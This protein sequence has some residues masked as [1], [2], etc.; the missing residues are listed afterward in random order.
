MNDSETGPDRT[1]P[2]DPPRPWWFDAAVASLALL[3]ATLARSSLETVLGSNYPF[4]TYYGAVA[5]VAWFR[6]TAA[7]IMTLVI[8]GLLGVYLFTTDEPNAIVGLALYLAVAGVVVSMGHAMRQARCRA[9]SLLAEAVV[10]QNELRS[11]VVAEA[12]QRE[13]QIAATLESVKDGF[14]RFDRDWRIVYAN[15]EAERINRLERGEMLGRN[16]WELFP[17]LVGSTLETEFRRAVEQQ[18]TVE[19]ENRYE[20]WGRWYALKGYPTPDGGLTTFIRDITE[21][22]AQREAL[23]ES[24]ARYRAIGESIDFGVW[25]CDATGRNIYASKSFL[26]M[27]GLT[28]QQCSNMG[29]G[30]VLHPDD[31]EA[32]IAAW[33]EC[34][35]RRGKWDREHRIKGVDGQWY[36]VLARGVP[37]EN[38]AGESLGWAGINLDITRFV[39]T[40]REVARIAGE[41][42][43][44]RRLYETV[45]TNTPDFVYVFSLDHK[46]VYANDALLKMWGLGYEDAIGKTFLEIGYEPWHA[47][48]HDREIDLVRATRQPIR[49]EVPFNGTNGLRQYDYIFVPVIGADG[50]VEA[51]A[52]TTRDITDRLN[53]EER[54]RTNEERQTYRVT[55]ADSIRPLSDPAAVQAEAI[56]VLGE[57]IDASRVAYFEIHGDDFVVEQDYTDGVASMAGRYPLAAF[58]T[59]LMDAY[60]SGRNAIEAD[61]D[62]VDSLTPQERAAFATIQTRA[63]VG[64]PLVKDGSFVGGLAIHSARPR[65]WTSTE[66]SLVEETAERTWAAVERVRAESALRTSEER[67]RTLFGTMDEGFCVIDIEFDPAGRAIDYQIDVMNPAFEE[68]TG[69]QG[70][71]GKS[72]R[73]TVPALE[74][75]WF[76]TYGRVASTGETARFVH[77]AGPMGGRWFDVSAFRLGG[78]GSNKVGILFRDITARKHADAERE[79][80]VSQ[81][82]D[83]DRRKDEFLATLAHELRNPLAPIRN[84][85]QLIR[86][87]GAD[88]TIE[89]A[90]SMMERQLAQLVRLVDDLLDMNR[91]T[92]GKLELRRER[93]ELSA[94]VAAALETSRLL[95]EQ[96]G[97]ELS[98][99][100]PDESIFVD[101]DPVRLAQAVSNLLTNSAKYTHQGGRIRLSVARDDAM[102]TLT[103]ADDGIGIP[104]DMLETVFEMFTQVDRSLEKTTGGLGIGLSLVKGLV[105]MHGGTIVARSEGEGRGS[106]FVMRLPVAEFRTDVSAP[107]NADGN[108]AAPVGPRRILIV[109]DNID[110]ADSLGELLEVMGNEVRTVYDGAAAVET[111]RAFRPCV[112]LCDIGMPVLNGYDTA[113]R[114]RAEA[115]SKDTVLVAVTGWGQDGDLEKSAEAGFDH[116]LVKPVELATLMKLLGDHHPALG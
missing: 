64:V 25:V 109:D 69:M 67:L 107:G 83:Q 11:S 57:W 72:I 42:E 89:H 48:M 87:A 34:V 10:R 91:V 100:L 55:L 6:G 17:S 105:E 54:L 14:I 50:E 80:L 74:E 110:S 115:W 76:E 44:Q 24:E 23:A 94:V 35:E 30:T 98:V 1:E 16:L 82:R 39:A 97:H 116:H 19:F 73:Q 3:A 108:M 8:G 7:A 2:D 41:S 86:L 81:L 63:Y 21:Q 56:R 47:A 60:L 79:R 53:A 62:M 9:E 77:Q 52:G 93:V 99:D 92:T 106:E 114:I 65:V 36:H 51:V 70:L 85:L 112:V 71:A 27:T 33:R 96:A 78:D 75:F 59:R 104:A 49:G 88:E 45:L 20:P 26:T 66:V 18:V 15:A 46:V 58:G 101:G 13:Q 4:V 31:A 102:V 68:H 29:W 90:R 5:F 12:E 103:V 37:L 95:I 38:A 40:E 84:G 43:R 111:A 28:Q 22:K 32:T 61:V 113:R